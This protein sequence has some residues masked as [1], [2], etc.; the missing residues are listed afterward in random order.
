MPT[1]MSMPAPIL[2]SQVEPIKQLIMMGLA[3]FKGPISESPR[4]KISKTCLERVTPAEADISVLT[5]P[6]LTFAG[7]MLASI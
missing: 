6:R 3:I 2:P 5:T 7:S 4:C 1:L